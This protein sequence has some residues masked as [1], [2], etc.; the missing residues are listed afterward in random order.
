[1]N[2]EIKY[3][4]QKF[5]GKMLVCLFYTFLLHELDIVVFKLKTHFFNI[6]IFL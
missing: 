2:S 1:M 6:Y 4:K 5:G 3:E